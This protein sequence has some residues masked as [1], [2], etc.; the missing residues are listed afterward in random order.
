[1]NFENSHLSLHVYISLVPLIL[2]DL[3]ADEAM[4]DVYLNR[5]RFI[6]QTIL[7]YQVILTVLEVIED[8]TPNR[9]SERFVDIDQP[10][11]SPCK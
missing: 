6:E 2:P 8:A 5:T 4:I 11:A 9:F 7:I 1:M 3:C 10:R